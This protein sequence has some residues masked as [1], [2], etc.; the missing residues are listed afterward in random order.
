MAKAAIAY[1]ELLAR[2]APIIEFEAPVLDARS[3]GA[4]AA[5]VA[6]L[7]QARGV[8]LRVRALLDRSRRREAELSALFDTASD[9]A[10]LHDLS[11][12]LERIY[13]ELY[14]SRDAEAAPL[15]HL[16]RR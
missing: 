5:V 12:V 3:D 7:E 1:L 14:G 15:K 6:E 9:L 11:A 13:T 8:A 10:L 4:G 16:R 2:E